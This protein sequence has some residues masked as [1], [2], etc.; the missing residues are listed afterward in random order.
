MDRFVT[1]TQ[2]KVSEQFL[3][4]QVLLETVQKVVKTNGTVCL[5]GDYGVGKSWLVNYVLRGLS[6]F[7]LTT[8][9]IKDLERVENSV[10]HVVIDDIDIDKDV[11]EKIKSGH[12]LSKGSLIIVM[13]VA[14]K[15]DFCTCV[16]FKHPD[17]A[18]MVKIGLKHNP[19]ESVPRL[20]TLAIAARGNIRTFLYS[21]DFKESHDLF[22]TPKDFVSDLVCDTTSSDNPIKYLGSVISEHGYVWGV[23]H[24]NYIDVPGINFV[25]VAEC[26]SQAELLDNHIYNGNWDLLP[27]FCT[28][29]TIEPALE[30]GHQLKR[31]K[32]R[33]GSAWTKFG[34]HKMRLN[35]LIDIR[36]RTRYNID[37]E[38]LRLVMLHC[39]KSP[40]RIL[41]LF[42][43]YNL[44]PPDIDFINHL[45]LMDKLSA[46][47]IQ[48][49]KKKAVCPSTS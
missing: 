36:N 39:K 28:V 46:S 38:S 14:T 16:Y 47:Q 41:E 11:I 20:T 13:H 32:L 31:D 48:A 24:D 15:M 6:R 7:D 37:A 1:I 44:K 45:A 26:M 43:I 9:N 19:R 25:K 30:I 42:K 23:I 27:H 29:S 22:R 2:P 10:A 40:D 34:N 8:E 35:K 3:C 12:R 4:N 49:L 33:P 18:L 21:I 5:H 17:V